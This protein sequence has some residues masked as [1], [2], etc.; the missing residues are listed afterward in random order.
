VGGLTT[1]VD[2]GRT[3]YLADDPTPERFAEAVRRIGR[4][5]VLAER[6]STASVLRARQYTWR[7]AAARMAE[8][9][10]ELMT[11]RLVECG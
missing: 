10:D 6:F 1:L 9:H 4:D 2:D 8:I 7:A 11:G 3:G 5:S